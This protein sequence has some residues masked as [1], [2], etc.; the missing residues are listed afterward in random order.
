VTALG[1]TTAIF[2]PGNFILTHGDAWTS[3]LI[4]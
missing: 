3:R 1:E 2:E 4:R